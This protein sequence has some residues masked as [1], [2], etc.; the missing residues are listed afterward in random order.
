MLTRNIQYVIRSVLRSQ[1]AIK[2]LTLFASLIQTQVHVI[3][4]I[5]ETVLAFCEYVPRTVTIKITII[6]F[7]VINYYIYYYSILASTSM[8]HLSAEKKHSES[9]LSNSVIMVTVE[10]FERLLKPYTYS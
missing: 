8:H 3:P 6:I 4:N 7:N 10:R 1:H 2:T 5:K 9:Y